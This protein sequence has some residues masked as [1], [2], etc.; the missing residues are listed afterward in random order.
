MHAHGWWLTGFKTNCRFLWLVLDSFQAHGR[1]RLSYLFHGWRL[2]V[3]S[4]PPARR[5]RANQREREAHGPPGSARS[6]PARLPWSRCP[7][8]VCAAGSRFGRPPGLSEA[9]SFWVLFEPGYPDEMACRLSNIGL[10]LDIPPPGRVK[11]ER[12]GTP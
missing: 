12:V 2:R 9:G 1:F 5:W 11:W 10:G 4:C 7:V 6:G 8:C 3:M